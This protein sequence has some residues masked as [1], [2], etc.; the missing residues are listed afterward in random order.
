MLPCQRNCYVG[1]SGCAQCFPSSASVSVRLPVGV[2]AARAMEQLRV[3]DSVYTGDGFSK[4][5]SF[6]DHVSD[7]EASTCS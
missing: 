2:V 6:V 4:I 1:D 3:G 7:I 5:F